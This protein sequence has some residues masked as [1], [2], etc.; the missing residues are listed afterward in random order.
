MTRMRNHP[1]N[2]MALAVLGLFCLAP[3]ISRAA[4]KPMPVPPTL[5][6]PLGL[7]AGAGFR[8]R[9]EAV[10]ALGKH[11]TRQEIDALYAFM[12]KPLHDDALPPVE[13]NA[14]KNDMATALL[15]QADKPR[16]FGRQMTEMCRDPAQDAVWRDYCVQFLG[17]WYAYAPGDERR[18][19]RDALWAAVAEPGSGIAGT[20]LIALRNNI[21]GPEIDRKQLAEKACALASEP[22]AAEPTRITA[23]QVCALLKYGPALA[24]ARELA[25]GT[26]SACL[27][28][29]AIAAVGQLGDASDVGLLE[30]CASSRDT[31]IRTAAAAALERLRSKT[32]RGA[33]P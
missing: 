19:V 29:S 7:E 9:L 26:D 1:A 20:A 4:G 15:Q 11:L 3:A 13:L 28:V 14:L 12:H 22:K 24:V 16:D 25:S 21:S 33:A 30:R 8:A 18:E 27:R 6:L 17:A 23:L 31:R 5:R 2:C 32:A 10:H